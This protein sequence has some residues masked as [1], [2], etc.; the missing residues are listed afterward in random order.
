M[1]DIL[2]L[3][4]K[5]PTWKKMKEAPERIE[6]LE[7]RLANLEERLKRAP[8]EAC[9]RCGVL[10]YRVASSKKDPIMGEAGALVRTMECEEC[11]F[12]EDHTVVPGT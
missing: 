8:G 11:G 5:W 2:K 6:A 10:A 1:S 12:T 4:D 7:T 9:P 3:L